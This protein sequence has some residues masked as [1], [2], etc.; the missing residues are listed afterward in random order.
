MSV[1]KKSLQLVLTEAIII[2]IITVG[3]IQLTKMFILPYMPNL[4]GQ[5]E[6]VELFIIAGFLFHITLEYTG[7]NAWYAKEYCK[8]L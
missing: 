2:G 6:S 3:F 8:L 7:L 4:S 5:K 1:F